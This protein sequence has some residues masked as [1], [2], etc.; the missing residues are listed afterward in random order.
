MKKQIKQDKRCR[1]F[2]LTPAY[3]SQ[4]YRPTWLCQQREQ[5][6][7]Q[8]RLRAIAIQR[9]QV[10][11]GWDMAL[12]QA[13]PSRRLAP[14]GTVLFLKLKGDEDAIDK[15]IDQIWFS[16]VSDDVNGSTENPKQYRRDGFGLA[17]LGAWPIETY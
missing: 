10:V 16:C 1:L 8:P 7:V 12:R 17:V 14:A 6:G 13:K 15:W 2:L 11:S 3:F 4:G 9:P 5:L